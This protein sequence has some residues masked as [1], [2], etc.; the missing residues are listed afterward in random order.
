MYAGKIKNRGVTIIFQND[1]DVPVYGTLDQ[2]TQVL[3]RLMSNA[4]QAVPTGGRVWLN[5]TAYTDATEILVRDEGYGMNEEVLR[6]LFS[7][8]NWL[9]MPAHPRSPEWCG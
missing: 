1:A 4:L 5:F 3:A 6:N 8:C 7:P 9:S 2:I